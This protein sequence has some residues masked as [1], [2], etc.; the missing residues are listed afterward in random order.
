MCV[1][2]V[3]AWAV[4]RYWLPAVRFPLTDIFLARQIERKFPE[5]HERL[6]GAMAFLNEPNNAPGAGSAQL[7]RT[8]IHE[9][10]EDALRLPMTNI[11]Q[12]RPVWLAVGAAALVVAASAALA[13]THPDAARIGTARLAKPW[14]DDSWPQTNRLKFVDPVKRLAYGHRFRADVVDESGQELAGDVVLLTRRLEEDAPIERTV[15]RF[16]GGSWSAE[17][18][19]VTH[20]FAYR[21]VGGD[22][23]AMPWTEVKVVEPPIVQEIQWKVLYPAYAD[24]KPLETGPRPG[25]QNVFTTALPAGSKLEARGRTNKPLKSAVLRLEG[26]EAL[27]AVLTPDRLGFTLSTADGNVW[28]PARA[29]LTAGNSSATTAL[30]AA[31][32][33]GVNFSSKPIRLL[34]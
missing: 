32:I 18:A 26:D 33:Y 16:E 22:D 29:R 23:R 31:T 34:G 15:M 1:L 4:W 28:N 2:A 9:T 5:L 27:T 7:R 13:A 10:T 21:A 17:R 30:P 25:D 20:D 24:W 19:K 3:A 11:L 8:V 14:G 6:A 12:A